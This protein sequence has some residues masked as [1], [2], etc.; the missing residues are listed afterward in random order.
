MKNHILINPLLLL[1][2]KDPSN[3]T[4]TEI[5]QEISSITVA[6]RSEEDPKE[7]RK[8]GARRQE[9]E[10]A[11]GSEDYA[12]DKKE[13]PAPEPAPEPEA[14][15]EK[16]ADKKDDKG[17]EKDD[18]DPPGGG[19][20]TPPVGFQRFVEV[21][22]RA[23]NEILLDMESPNVSWVNIFERVALFSNATWVAA[24][25][26][27]AELE[28]DEEGKDITS[29][30]AG[31]V[32]IG[33][34]AYATKAQYAKYKF[35]FYEKIVKEKGLLPRQAQA[36]AEK[37]GIDVDISYQMPRSSKP[38]VFAKTVL[39][40]IFGSPIFQIVVGYGLSK[41]KIKG[42]LADGLTKLD[43][44]INAAANNQAK[45]VLLIA[46]TEKLA[47]ALQDIDEAVAAARSGGKVSTKLVLGQPLTGKGVEE[48]EALQQAILQQ[49]E[50]RTKELFAISNKIEDNID[51]IDREARL[52]V[53]A[54]DDTI[55]EAI[56]NVKLSDKA[57][58]TIQGFVDKINPDT[59]KPPPLPPGVEKPEGSLNKQT[60]ELAD[61]GDEKAPWYRRLID[62]L[63]EIHPIFKRLEENKEGEQLDIKNF[64]ADVDLFDVKKAQE[65]EDEA[66]S[67][68]VKGLIKYTLK[69]SIL[70]ASRSVI[71]SLESDS[72]AAISENKI[73]I[74]KSKLIDLISEQV[75][76][77]TQTVDVTKDQ[78]VALVAQEAF[79]Q[80]SRK[81]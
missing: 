46:E 59:P 28:L 77:Q 44:D 55:D 71:A 47:K 31:L 68:I 7:L 74:T 80:I 21:L 40:I 39:N 70:S 78:L 36:L 67:Y 1:E 4:K 35:N 3:M 64:L 76:E 52:A 60:Q 45:R 29:V 43:A 38:K 53:E 24:R 49:N 32:H 2:Q 8:L 22:M 69:M 12:P 19:D 48:L 17:G 33:L 42:V 5:E 18:S 41:A 72:P 56:D 50:V 62:A 10:D 81:K 65:L 57:R 34:T 15:P 54:L 63:K 9:L 58:Q 37:L 25:A 11:I 14:A 79:K 26:A 61:L 73:R 75:R 20:P 6:L 16:E 27:E 13:E 23:V 66:L 51:A 30:I